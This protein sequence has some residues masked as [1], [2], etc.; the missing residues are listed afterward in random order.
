[1]L[2]LGLIFLL[3]SQLPQPLAPAVENTLAA[4][5]SKDVSRVGELSFTPNDLARSYPC[6]KNENVD[7]TFCISLH[8]DRLVRSSLFDEIQVEIL[9]EKLAWFSRPAYFTTLATLWRPSIPIALG[10]LTI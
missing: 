5:Y 1:M 4:E 8:G 7:L 9:T 2:A 6:A 3:A 10:K